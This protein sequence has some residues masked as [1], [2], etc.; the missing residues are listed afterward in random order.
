MK[1]FIKETKGSFHLELHIFRGS[2]FHFWWTSYILQGS[3][4]CW[5][6]LALWIPAFWPR[7]TGWGGLEVVSAVSESTRKLTD[8]GCEAPLPTSGWVQ[9][10]HSIL[11]VSCLGEQ[12]PRVKNKTATKCLVFLFSWTW[13]NIFW[14]NFWLTTASV[15]A[16]EGVVAPGE[17]KAA[18]MQLLCKDC[19]YGGNT[20]YY[21]EAGGESSVFICYVSFYI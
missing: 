21:W 3:I 5:L 2:L 1:K 13:P 4:L 8:V 20:D 9:C 10:L 17:S 15:W 14:C 7:K 12:K 6:V 18:E 11:R 19:Y 16:S